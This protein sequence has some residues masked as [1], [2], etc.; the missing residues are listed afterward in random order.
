MA[1]KFL[2][3]LSAEA[4]DEDVLE[5]LIPDKR[6]KADKAARSGGSGRRKKRFIDSINESLPPEPTSSQ[7]KSLLE[8]ME[9]ALDNQVFDEIFPK[10]TPQS[11]EEDQ[12]LESRF[13]TMITTDVLDRARQIANQK[14]IRVKDVINTALRIYV[15]NEWENLQA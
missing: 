5:G 11:D 4:Y 7:R 1:K 3:I 9:E 10:R 14:G 2:D 15:E 13:S 12:Q 8:T 6:K